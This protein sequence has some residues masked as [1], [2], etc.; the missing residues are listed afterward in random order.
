[1]LTL[2]EIAEIFMI[3]GFHVLSEGAGIGVAFEATGDFA[4]V[5]F[6]VLV[7]SAV[8]K[9]ITGVAVAFG[10]AR[11][12]TFVGFFKRVRSDVNF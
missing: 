5:G 7:G 11:K 8:L 1:V 9:T 10:A 12:T 6:D 2:I 3:E 4:D